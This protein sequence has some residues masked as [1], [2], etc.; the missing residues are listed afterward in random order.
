MGYRIRPPIVKRSRLNIRESGKDLSSGWVVNMA[1]GCSHGCI[2][3][4]A[5]S[6][7]KRFHVRRVPEARGEWGSF[8]VP[9]TNLG[10]AIGETDWGR[11]RGEEILL[12]SIHDPYLPSLAPYTRMVLMR[13]LEAGCRFTIL[14]RSPLVMRDYPLLRRFR[15]RVRVMFS[16][17][18]LD[19]G[20]SRLTEPYAPLPASRLRALRRG[21]EEGLVMGVVIAPLFPHIPSLGYDPFHVL[22]E[23]FHAVAPYVRYVYGEA[24]HMRGLNRL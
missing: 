24:L 21:Y 18:S 16:I 2:F 5:D 22:E 9:A 10:E 17:P 15:G 23:V 13:G 7:V 12:S 19:P 1:V 4:Y 14:T 8:L 20:W 6:V 11:W 3:C